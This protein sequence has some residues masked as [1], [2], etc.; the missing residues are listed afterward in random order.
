MKAPCQWGM[1]GDGWGGSWRDADNKCLLVLR[2]RER[3]KYFQLVR[4]PRDWKDAKS[5]RGKKTPPPLN[6]S[7]EAAV[8][9]RCV[10]VGRP[11][12]SR[13][14]RVPRGGESHAWRQQQQAAA[15]L[16][17]GCSHLILPS[18]PPAHTHTHRSIQTHTYIHVC[19]VPLVNCVNDLLCDRESNW[20]CCTDTHI[21]IQYRR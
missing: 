3:G 18:V 4:P 13:R 10:P 15:R 19:T 21:H 11:A 12:A 17:C 8:Q 5:G 7:R 14:L 9:C 1:G 16:S 6:S 2:E 20:I